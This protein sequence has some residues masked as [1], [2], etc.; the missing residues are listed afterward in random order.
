MS[1]SHISAAHRRKIA[2]R[3]A[4]R[5][6][7]CTLHDDDSFLGCEIDHIIS[8]KHGGITEEENLA[9]CCFYC[10]RYKGSDLSTLD[11][12]GNLIRLFNPRKDRWDEHFKFQTLHILGITNIGKATAK[13]LRFNDPARI[14]ERAAMTSPRKRG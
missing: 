13:L 2:A 12:K 14:D 7:Y 11:A 3:A 9:F 1:Q 10:N 5:C 8:E 4:W 6:E